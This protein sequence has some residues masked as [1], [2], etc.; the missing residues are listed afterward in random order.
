MQKTATASQLLHNLQQLLGPGRVITD[1]ERNEHYRKGFRSGDGPALAVVFPHQLVAFWRVLNCCVDAGAII[2]LQ[3]ANTGLTEGSTPSGSDYDRPVVI[4][5]TLQMRGIHLLDDGRQIVA[6]PGATLHNLERL[7]TPLKR[8]PHSEIGSSC[9]GASII[10]GIANNSGGALCQRGPAYTELA[11]FAQVD[12]SGQLRLVNHL[13]I[14]LGETPEEILT[15]LEQGT[16]AR[17][18]DLPYSEQEP[19]PRMASDREY[20]QRIRDVDADTP[21][22]FNADARRLFEASGCAGKVAVFAVRL[23]TFP[24]PE[25]TQTFYIGSNDPTVFARLRR[26]LLTE[27][28][29]LPILGEYLHRD[30]F[31]MAAEYGKDSFYIIEKLG[32]GNMPRFFAI[33]GR[34]DAWLEKRRFLPR[35]LTDRLL[36]KLS[37]L[38]P[39]HLPQRMRDYRKQFEHHLIVK[40]ADAN[41]APAQT[42]LNA[43]FER[44]ENTGDFFAC[45]PTE[46][47]KAMLHRF[48]AAGAAMRYQNVHSEEVGELLPLDI[49]LRRNDGDWQEQLPDAMESQLE[50]RLYYGHFMCNV[51]HQDYILKKNADP[52]K[53]KA[54]LLK[55]LDQRGARYPAEHNVGH[56]YQ[57]DEPLKQ[58]YQSLDPTNTFNPGIGKTD[59]HQ[60]H[61]S[62]G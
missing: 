52:K 23:D 57:A 42:W 20:S 28:P 40:V 7:L 37:H 15:N 21:A 50:R 35:F 60:R 54:A 16:F 3:A 58:F 26:G 36:Q 9:I 18:D 59:R 29:E 51:F 44:D 45:T 10:G 19:R 47:A 53:V 11:L 43:F 56:L 55:T 14:D 46:A 5:N 4:I 48:V 33:K 25:R 22:R 8:S 24:I 30:M 31:D 39:E 6:L 62:C 13:G 41:I 2:I 17:V 1:P 49:A 27:L 12:A 32:T 61:C 34:V 38:L